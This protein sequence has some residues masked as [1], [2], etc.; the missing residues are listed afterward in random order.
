MEGLNKFELARVSPVFPSQAP[1]IHPLKSTDKQ[2]HYE[3]WDAVAII[4]A[5]VNE[6]NLL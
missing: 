5:K 3:E 1:E 4:V 2:L 6:F